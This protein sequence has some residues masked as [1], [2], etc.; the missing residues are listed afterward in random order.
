MMSSSAVI[1]VTWHPCDYALVSCDKSKRVVVWTDG[2][3]K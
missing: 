1:A 3:F 2:G